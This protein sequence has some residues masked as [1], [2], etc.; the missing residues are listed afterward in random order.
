MDDLLL[1]GYAWKMGRDHSGWKK[2]WLVLKK[3]VLEMFTSEKAAAKNGSNKRTPIQLQV[4]AL[5]L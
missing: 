5:F 2:K 3:G 1:Q 4:Y